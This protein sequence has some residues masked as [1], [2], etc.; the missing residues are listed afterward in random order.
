MER[1]AHRPEA[2]DLAHPEPVPRDSDLP[3][4]SDTALMVFAA[5]ALIATLG[6]LALLIG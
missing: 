3:A 2:E 1:A 6:A 4:L 5:A